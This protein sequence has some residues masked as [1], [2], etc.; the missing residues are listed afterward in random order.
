MFPW[1]MLFQGMA[2]SL[3]MTLAL[4]L[5]YARLWGVR[6]GHDLILTILVNVLTNP[7]V[8][9]SISY[10]RIKRFSGNRGLLTAGLEIF[11]VVT[12]ALLYRRFSRTIRR[13]WLFSLSAN[14]F[15]YAVGELIN[16]IRGL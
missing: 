12:E 15:S 8:V 3:V 9:F 6:G 4:E 11:A 10:F 1:G 2:I 16:G 13:P 7:I 5:A 14:A